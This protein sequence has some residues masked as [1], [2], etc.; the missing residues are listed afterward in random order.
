MG[1]NA[2]P[3]YGMARCDLQKKGEVNFIAEIN[4]E[5]NEI[6]VL[7]ERKKKDRE[8]VKSGSGVKGR[9][10]TTLSDLWT[11]LPISSNIHEGHDAFKAF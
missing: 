11:V 4:K 5:K 2:G 3:K 8:G 9:C 10:K 7:Q 6:G 1:E